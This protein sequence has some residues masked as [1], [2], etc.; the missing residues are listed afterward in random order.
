M[1]GVEFLVLDFWAGPYQNRVQNVS[2]HVSELKTI[3]LIALIYRYGQNR[4][5]TVSGP[6]P[7]RILYLTRTRH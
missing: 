1:D 2:E 6:N 4:R 7:Y 5:D 3:V